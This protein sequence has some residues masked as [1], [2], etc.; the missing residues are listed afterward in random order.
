[1]FFYKLLAGGYEE[2]YETIYYSDKKVSQK[3]FEE[4]VFRLYEML[5]QKT[6]DDDPSSLCFYNIHFGVEDTLWDYQGEFKKLMEQEGF[7][8]LNNELTASMFFD[9]THYNRS[10]EYNRRLDDIFCNLNIDES[11]WDNDCPPLKEEDDEFRRYTKQ[12][13]GVTYLKGKRIKNKTCDN[14]SHP[15]YENHCKGKTTCDDWQWK[16]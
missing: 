14:C 5:C 12:D 11:C 9:L 1:M 8:E 13:C 4:T 6:V 15:Y 16:I 2:H 3:E 10:K 7:Y